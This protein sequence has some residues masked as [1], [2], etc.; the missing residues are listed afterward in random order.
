MLVTEI[1]RIIQIFKFPQRYS[2]YQLQERPQETLPCFLLPFSLTKALL[3]ALQNTGKLS[4]IFLWL[5]T[6][7]PSKEI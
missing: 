6:R 4:A 2:S 7:T 5:S 1:E 3:A